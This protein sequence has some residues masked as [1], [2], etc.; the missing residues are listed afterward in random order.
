MVEFLNSEQGEI[1]LIIKYF[2]EDETLGFCQKLWKS[3]KVSC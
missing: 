1:F 3:N 2:E